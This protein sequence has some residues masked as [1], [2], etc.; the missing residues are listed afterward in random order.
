[1]KIFFLTLI[2]LIFATFKVSAATFELD[3]NRLLDDSICAYSFDVYIDTQGRSS[4]AAD[5]IIK[6]SPE[7]VTIADSDPKSEGTQI[8]TRDAFESYIYNNAQE[9]EIKV[10]AVRFD[11]LSGR[12]LF[13]TVPFIA[14]N[15]HPRFVI[16]FAG[17]GNTYDSNIAELTTSLDILTGVKNISPELAHHEC[18]P[19]KDSIRINTPSVP[20]DDYV[21]NIR[22]TAIITNL[23]TLLTILILLMLFRFLYRKEIYLTDAKTNQP[24]E[25]VLISV[26][27][28]KDIKYYVSNAQGRAWVPRLYLN[29]LTDI[30]KLKYKN[31]LLKNGFVRNYV[32]QL[33]PK[34]EK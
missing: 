1:M 15:S 6:Y 13:A 5:L 33:E 7:E 28:E 8:I 9:G 3:G 10:T 12:H 32:Y 21:K 22:F 20:E 17:E 24:V 23:L 31:I 34:A 30:E 4:N 11:Y 14:H 25:G 19:I 27:T 26:K 29:Y 18:I 16:M 2:I